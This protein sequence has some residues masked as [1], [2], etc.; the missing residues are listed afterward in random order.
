MDKVYQVSIRTQCV[1]N[2]TDKYHLYQ[3]L[4]LSWKLPILY[5]VNVFIKPAKFTKQLWSFKQPRENIEE[6]KDH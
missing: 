1:F 4:W 6:K 5:M 2:I 3:Q